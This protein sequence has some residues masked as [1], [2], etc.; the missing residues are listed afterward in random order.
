MASG[1]ITH[2]CINLQSHLYLLLESCCWECL[3]NFF[4]GLRSDFDL[5]PKMFL[6]PA[7]VAGFMRVLILHNPGMLK[8]PVFF[9]SLAAISTKDLSR[10]EL[11]FCFKPCSSANFFVIC[12]LV[13]TLAAAPLFI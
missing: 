2:C 9:T 12:P 5:L 10:S 8:M 7:L 13:M 4:C 11:A 1:N 6:T 3:H